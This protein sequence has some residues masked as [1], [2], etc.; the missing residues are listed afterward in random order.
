[1]EGGSGEQKITNNRQSKET[2]R[3]AGCMQGETKTS[4]DQDFT[5][6]KSVELRQGG[7][8]KQRGQRDKR[9]LRGEVGLRQIL[10]Q[11]GSG[12]WRNLIRTASYNMLFKTNHYL[13]MA[14][15]K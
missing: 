5:T 1:M 7:E 4:S 13:T 3:L 11:S 6:M 14:K 15:A 9:T 10:R 2:S 12:E 8:T